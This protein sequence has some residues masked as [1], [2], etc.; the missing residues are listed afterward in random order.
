MAS[1]AV[2][3]GQGA[4]V[5]YITYDGLADPLGRSQILPYLS[6]LAA[7]GHRICVL[8][9]EKPERLAKDGARVCQ[10]CDA[11]GITWHPL[12]YHKQPPVV[13][14]VFDL[15]RMRAAAL[16]LQRRWSFDLVH[17]RGH[18]PAIIGLHLKRRF[19]TAL[20]FDPRGFWPEEKVEGKVWDLRNPVYAK[21]HSYIK[22][23]EKD[24]LRSSEQI[25]FLTYAGREELLRR[26]EL[27]G[28]GER[29]TVIPCCVDFDH[30]QLATAAERREAR[31]G[32]GIGAKEPVLLYLGSI[33]E[34]YMLDEMLDFFRTYLERY[35]EARFLFVTPDPE[36]SIRSTAEVRGIDPGR[37]IIRS[38]SREEVPNLM[39]A[40]DLGICFIRPLFSKTGSSPTKLGEMIAVGLPV[41]A[42]GPVGDVEAIVDATRCGVALRE[43]SEGAYSLALDR[44]ELLDS[45]A[46]DRRQAALPWFD[47][48]I[49][50]ERYHRAY[51]RCL[52]ERRRAEPSTGQ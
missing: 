31:T 35:P 33:G 43:F 51:L 14:T 32:L 17:C 28:H 2:T 1:G 34:W 15:A 12:T 24:L 6:R 8:S 3:K 36:S 42:N 30:F 40:A 44:I 29:V 4:R 48:S 50:V 13:S 22:K 11:A 18:L 45:E 9:C 7:L 21:V 5:L 38:A 23:V 20:L 10:L 16:R 39:A 41:V 47:L 27:H 46:A 25:V 49:G 37:L 52:A 19:G 26:P